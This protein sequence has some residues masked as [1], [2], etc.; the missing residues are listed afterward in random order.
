M[1]GYKDLTI[2][3]SFNTTCK[4]NVL[5]L[6]PSATKVSFSCQDNR[7][8]VVDLVQKLMT[9][10]YIY[11]DTLSE[12]AFLSNSQLITVLNGTVR[13]YVIPFTDQLITT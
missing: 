11:Y 13:S 6:S 8:Y 9:T 7:I 5:A 12:L 10:M 2:Q 1:Q 3:T 4:P